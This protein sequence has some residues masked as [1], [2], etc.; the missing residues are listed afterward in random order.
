MKHLSLFNGI[1]GFQLAAHWCGW[2]NV[3]HVE[4]DKK[5]NEIVN[6][7]FPYSVAYEDIKKFNGTKYNGTIDIISGGDP[8]QP[9]SI[10]GLGNGK[11]DNRYLWS[12]MFRVIKEVRPAWVVNENVTGSIS[13]GIVDIKIN[14]LESIGYTCRAFV[15]PAE[16][17][18]ALHKRERVWLIAYDSNSLPKHRKSYNKNK[19]GNK[20]RTTKR[21]I[22]HIG[23]PV[24]L[25]INHSNS[26]RKRPQE[27]NIAPK[28]GILQ[29]SISRYFGF[30]NNTYGNITR[31]EI[32]SAIIRSLNGLP[33]GLDYPQRNRRIKALGNAIVPQ[34]TYQIFKAIGNYEK[35]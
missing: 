29:E 10:A 18:G 32:K 9:H 27:L 5:L 3:A 6:Q 14:D 12:E 26:N 13:N 15:I 2:S 25:R 34:V 16:A 1:G 28:P 4:I 7:Y 8:C 11:E 20:K 30:G 21:K 35:A 31:N 19:T 33:E 17:V 23:E 24:N 22:Q